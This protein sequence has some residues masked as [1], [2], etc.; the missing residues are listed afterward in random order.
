M[1]LFEISSDTDAIYYRLLF[2]DILNLE[3][4]KSK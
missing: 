1:K 4:L 3:K 2:S